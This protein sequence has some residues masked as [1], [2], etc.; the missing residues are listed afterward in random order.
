M[1]Q[2]TSSTKT[3]TIAEPD[4][5]LANLLKLSGLV[6]STSDAHRLVKQ[7]AVRID[8]ERVS[9]SRQKVAEGTTHIFRVGK[10]RIAR[11]EVLANHSAISGISLSTYRAS[12]Q[13]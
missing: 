10:R 12:F 5:V 4:I 13:K 1:I 9:D 3:I 2:T 8:G 7:G 11:V 6:D